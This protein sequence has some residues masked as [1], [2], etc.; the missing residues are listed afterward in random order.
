VTVNKPCPVCKK[1]S[2]ENPWSAPCTHQACYACW[3]KALAKMACPVCGK[4]TQKR[5]MTKAYFQ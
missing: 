3:V 2:M 5:N 4:R 1:A